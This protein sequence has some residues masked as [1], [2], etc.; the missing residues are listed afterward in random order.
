MTSALM[1]AWGAGYS[2]F[3]V[4]TNVQTDIFNVCYDTSK[5]SQI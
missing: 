5:R 3:F 1:T 2:V 4:V